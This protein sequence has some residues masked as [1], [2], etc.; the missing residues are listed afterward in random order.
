MLKIEVFPEHENKQSKLIPG[1]EGKPAKTIYEQTAYAY[2][3][4]K[5]PVE[6]KLSLSEE[7]QA[8]KVGLYTLD[9][10]SFTVNNFGSL[11]LKRYGLKIVE[12]EDGEL[13]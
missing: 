9:S 1:K 13:L 3:G 6:I 10:S 12:L 8:Y 5:F 2:L 7:E 4:G 11:E